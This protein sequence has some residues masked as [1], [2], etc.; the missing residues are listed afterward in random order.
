[1]NG[2]GVI[3]VLMGVVIAYLM[4][5]RITSWPQY[6]IGYTSVIVIHWIVRK[7]IARWKHIATKDCPDCRGTGIEHS[8]VCHCGASMEGHSLYDNHTATEM[9]RP[10]ETCDSGKRV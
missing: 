3:I 7:V 1:M 2:E 10:C 8:G 9:T 4:R 6:V 5:G